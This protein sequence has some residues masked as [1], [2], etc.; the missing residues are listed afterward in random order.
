ML[1]RGKAKRKELEGFER[2]LVVY[3]YLCCSANWRMP[4]FKYVHI[5]STRIPTFPQRCQSLWLFVV[6]FFQASSLEQ[7]VFT[8]KINLK[9]LVYSH[10][11]RNYSITSVLS[12]YIICNLCTSV[13]QNHTSF[14]TFFYRLYFSP[15]DLFPLHFSSI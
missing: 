14:L 8:F 13:I 4:L 11:Y 1:F 15:S 9:G 2:M 10:Y 3:H 6:Y 5:E 12:L 7:Y